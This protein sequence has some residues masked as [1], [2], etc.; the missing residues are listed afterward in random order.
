MEAVD[1]AGVSARVDAAA[2]M[3]LLPPLHVQFTKLEILDKQ[4]YK[5]S[6]EPIFQ[7]IRLPFDAFVKKN[8]LFNPHQMRSIRL[9]FDKT[10][11]RVVI[12]SGV[13]LETW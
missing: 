6:S 5:D 9:I 4:W 2:F 7:T 11:T 12:L 10:P 8:G 3:Q 13:G 1:A